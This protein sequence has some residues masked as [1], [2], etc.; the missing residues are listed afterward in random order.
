M[1]IIDAGDIAIL[2]KITTIVQELFGLPMPNM[3]KFY[4]YDDLVI[5]D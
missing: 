4:E 1:N 5:T 2:S 3:Q